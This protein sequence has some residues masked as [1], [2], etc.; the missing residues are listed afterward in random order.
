MNIFHITKAAN[1]DLSTHV[2]NNVEVD[3]IKRSFLLAGVPEFDA[4]TDIAF[5]QVLR[6]TAAKYKTGTFWRAILL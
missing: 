3:D 6:S 1:V 5:V 2:V 4:D